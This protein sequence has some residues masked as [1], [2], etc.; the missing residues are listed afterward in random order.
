[1]KSLLGSDDL[2]KLPE[3]LQ[4][5]VEKA[6]REKKTLGEAVRKSEGAAENFEKI[7]A[8]LEET[9]A[10]IADLKSQLAE[11]QQ[12][13]AIKETHTRIESLDDRTRDLAQSYDQTAY[14]LA[15]TLQAANDLDKRMVDL[16]H[17]AGELSQ[18]K[19]DVAKLSGPEGM[20]TKIQE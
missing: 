9:K 13:D 7:T 20:V 1:M 5:L 3:N 16:R 12:S 11:M 6:R 17:I 15:E 18:T 2:A 14:S 8:P 10:A 4:K 19:D